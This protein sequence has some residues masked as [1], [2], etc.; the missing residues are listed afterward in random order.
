MADSKLTVGNVEIVGLSDAGL[1]FPFTLDQLFPSVPLERWEPYR[2]RYPE[3]FGGPNVWHA[4]FGCYLLRSQGRTIL[5]DTGIGPSNAP[6]AVVLQTGGQ[7][8]EKLRAEGVS[9]E[10]VDTVVFTHLHPDH[11]GWNVQGEADQLRLT[12]PRARHIAHRA[13]W[14]TFQRPEVKEGFPFPYVDQI[15]TPLERLGAL[16]L[17]DGERALTEE[18]TILHT[19]GH[20]PGHQS[21]LINSGGA[22]AIITGDAIAHPI[23]VTE[24]EV[25][26]SFEMDGPLAAETRRRL[27]D[28]IEAEGMTI[29]ACH[30]PEPGFG[31]LIRLEGRRYWQGL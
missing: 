2:Q 17:N 20:T 5:V 29:A 28:R 13:D 18:M 14:E 15:V 27:M 8:L 19:P 12:F 11:T 21:V 3:V 4:D 24:P 26:F 7:L 25:G 23:Q 6:I 16:E 22:R 1:D 31:R 30:F 10:D 9:P